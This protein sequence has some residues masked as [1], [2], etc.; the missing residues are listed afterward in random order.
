[1]SAT[2]EEEADTSQL[3]PQ[4][5][6][7]SAVE[8]FAQAE[9]L[10]SSIGDG[11]VATDEFGKIT[12]VNKAALNILGFTEKDV[13]GVWFPK[14]IQA[15]D[16]S[17]KPVKHIDRAI[18]RAFLTGK[19]ITERSLYKQKDGTLL[20]V[21]I[22][23]SPLVLT[24]RPIGAVGLF[25]DISTEYEIDRMKSDFISLASHQLRTPLSAIKTYTHMLMDG[26]MGNVSPEQRKALRTIISATNRMN[27]LIST[28]LNVSRIESG[29]VI[30]SAKKINLNHITGEVLKELAL[31]ADT[32]H[33]S[34]NQILTPLPLIIKGDNLIV[35]EILMNL[36]SN[37]IKYTTEG[38]EVTIK[39]KKGPRNVLI[40]VQDNGIG[41]PKSARGQVFSKF[42]RAQN[43]IRHET[44]GTG[45][46]LYLVEG[47][48]E[49][50]GGKIWFDSIENQGSTFYVRLPIEYSGKP[51]VKKE[52]ISEA[53]ILKTKKQ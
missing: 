32:K 25:R 16:D 2:T 20:P 14:A 23:V 6:L 1:M 26:F 15:Y 42:Y 40:T 21:S 19:P 9:A 35:K 43:V 47:L 11:A 31:A 52:Q 36:V 27:E 29:N 37:A 22:T 10:F 34:V 38:G 50:L 5:T 45:L 3:A 30:I 7:Q 17:G 46:G 53:P 18:T 41:I 12:K 33:I 24:G 39:F 49:A 13:L 51:I 48:V 4:M 8:A 28:L 44:S